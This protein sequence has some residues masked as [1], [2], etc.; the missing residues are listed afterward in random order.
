[1]AV[2]SSDAALHDA[3]ALHRAGKIPE[4]EAI[5][6]AILERV[7]EHPEALHHLGLIEAERGRLDEA[8]RLMTLSDR[9]KPG[10]P[11]W[12]FNLGRLAALRGDLPR[13]RDLFASVL[14][15]EPGN[16]DAA[17]SLGSA[18]LQ[19]GHLP[20]A[21]AQLDAALRRA[22]DRPDA[23][24]VLGLTEA[25]TGNLAE[26][27]RLCREAARRAPE[28]ADARGNLGHVLRTLG[29]D[30]EAAAECRQA[31][32]LQP[33]HVEAL[34]NLGMIAYDRRALDEARDC[35][36]RALRARPGHTEARFGLAE[37]LIADGR[38]SEGRAV[39]ADLV[40]ENP[41]NWR[42]RWASLVSFPIVYANQNEIDAERRRFADALDHF[43]ANVESHL[44]DDAAAM[45]AAVGFSTNFH[46]HYSGGDVRPLQE[47]YGRLIG[48]IAEAA[49]PMHAQPLPARRAEGKIR[50]GFA[51]SFFHRHSV[52][53]SHGCW[54]ADLPRDR[55][56]VVLFHL[57]G[58]IDDTTEAIRSAARWIACGA[59]TQAQLIDRLTAESL[60]ALIWL[61]IGMDAK[62]QIPAALRLA[63]LQATG[64][65][66][67]V[68]SGLT[69]IDAYLTGELMEPAGG[70]AHYTEA[71][72]RL[73]NLSV[74]YAQPRLAVGADA[75]PVPEVI[76]RLKNDGRVVYL[77]AQSLF[78]LT[79]TQDDL[80]ARIAEAV[81]NAA[82]AFIAH[83]SSRATE[84]LRGRLARRLKAQGIAPEGRMVFLPR[85]SEA[86]FL[87]AN[88]AVD[89]VLDSSEWSGFNSTLEALATGTPVVAMPGATMRAHHSHGI[90]TMAGLN[91]LIAADADGYVALAVRLGRDPDF[92]E[93]MGRA[94][95]ER[96][97]RVFDDLK[98]VAALADWLEHAVS[99]GAD[100]A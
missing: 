37:A 82:F 18:L 23:L 46:L 51:S 39:L 89:V 43:A 21:R 55:F 93:R 28:W 47:R 84:V 75:G 57:G 38:V 11:D 20:S 97:G 27:E 83:P 49:Y 17:I 12:R 77:C 79:P 67:P 56:E 86:A 100:R 87:A 7:P 64:F 24:T 1:M 34:V 71:L 88:R 40:R 99:A 62:V 30:A 65:G 41:R 8:D 96:R 95:E 19:L 10:D 22:P 25:A 63:R 76:Q 14:A 54:I 15:Q 73:P 13:S 44:A 26:A 72:V 3:F 9:L 42:A 4:A 31:L 61:D 78:K 74:S 81:P 90:L 5:Y 91:E 48:R 60:D 94:V 35:F 85:L 53:K 32:A 52:M 98:P 70:E 59:L 16:I 69:T 68:T 45:A 58:P 50:V 29:R 92:R 36:E 66:H 80:I 33:G 6:R 2:T